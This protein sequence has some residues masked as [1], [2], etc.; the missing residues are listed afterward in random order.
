MHDYFVR[1]GAMAEIQPA[2]AGYPLE[3]GQRVIVRTARGVELATVA[4][5][6]NSECGDDPGV[7]VLRATTG[8]DELLLRRLE[9]HKR[10][11]VESCR[12]ELAAAGS[13]ATLLEVDQVFDGGTLV[14]HFLGPIDELAQAV[15]ERVVEKYESVVKSRHFAKLLKEGCGP[16]CGTEAGSGC[17]TAGGC[18]SCGLAG[19]C[20]KGE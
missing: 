8:E 17:G 6:R 14:M 2:R 16:D 13:N 20:G 12:R 19:G 3:P 11:A 9:R 5:A 7:Q 1:I 10:E 15:T 4:A 18:A